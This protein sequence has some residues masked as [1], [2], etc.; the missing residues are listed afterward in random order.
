MYN[1]SDSPTSAQHSSVASAR[2]HKEGLF[3]NCLHKDHGRVRMPLLCKRDAW[4]VR[5]DGQGTLRRLWTEESEPG[6]T[7]D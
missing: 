7:C 2:S 3:T 6:G 5:I 4:A 1:S